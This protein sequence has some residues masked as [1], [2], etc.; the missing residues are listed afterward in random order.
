[1]WINTQIQGAP[2]KSEPLQI[3]MIKRMLDVFME[4]FVFAL[5]LFALHRACVLLVFVDPLLVW[6]IFVTVIRDVFVSVPVLLIATVM[7]SL[8]VEGAAFGM[9]VVD[10]F[11]P[12]VVVRLWRT[13]FALIMMC[14]W[15]IASM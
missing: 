15:G 1:M 14:M 5:Q 12:M 10:T 6:I 8:E 4:R 9:T 2:A 11:A 7:K 13:A 3:L